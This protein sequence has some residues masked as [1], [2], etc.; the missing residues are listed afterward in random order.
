MSSPK[1]VSK[2]S[3]WQ[4]PCFVQLHQFS[5]HLSED[6]FPIVEL[7]LSEQT[8]RWVPRAVVALKQ[9]AP[10]GREREHD[11][12]WNTQCASEMTKRGINGDDKV[13]RGDHGSRIAKIRLFG[14][15]IDDATAPR[16]RRS[17][18]RG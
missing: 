18:F 16:H 15:K 6:A 4:R 8:R 3:S 11:P 12:D 14:A 5:G 7:R 9:P 13:Q 2:V 10:F 1:P 17:I